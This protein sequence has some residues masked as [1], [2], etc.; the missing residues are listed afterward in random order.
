MASPQCVLSR[1]GM[2]RLHSLR[3]RRGIMSTSW[4]L[5]HGRRRP[6][7][8]RRMRSGFLR[9][10]QKPPYAQYNV[11]F[12]DIIPWPQAAT[13]PPADAQRIS[14]AR[15]ETALCAG[16]IATYVAIIP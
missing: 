13:V 1:R 9:Q 8:P 16:I 2:A 6:W 7:C 4:T 3:E 14:A 11:H 15:A 5:Y 10:A 12:V